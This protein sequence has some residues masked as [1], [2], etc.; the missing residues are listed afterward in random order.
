MTAAVMT[1]GDMIQGATFSPSY[2]GAFIDWIDRT[3]NT[4]K[5]YVNH[6]RQFWAWT[7][8]REILQPIREDI[9][10]FREW[11]L[12]EHEAITIDKAGKWT[13]RKD[14]ATGKPFVLAC[15]PT[16]TAQY[17]RSIK[18]FFRWTS[19]AGLY[20]DIAENI[21]P[22]KVSYTMHRRDALTVEQV[23]AVES[24]I[25]ESSRQGIISAEQ[26][27]K[28]TKGRTHRK[29]EQ[30]ARLLAMYQLAVI[31]GLRTV[32]LSRARVKDFEERGGRYYL[33]IQ[34][35]GHSEADERKPLAPEVA[36]A[37]KEYLHIRAK[38]FSLN[39]NSP[40][41]VATGNRNGGGKLDPRTISTIIKDAL[42]T[43]GLNSSRI[44]AHSLRHTA[45]T[46][47]YGITHDL[48]GVQK[49]MRHANP[50]TTEIYL[51]NDTEKQDADFT[52]K[53]YKLFH[54]ENFSI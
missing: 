42:K 6:L 31:N 12:S 48:Y 37:I 14:R 35:K 4:A 41:F 19:A 44:T 15:T 23:K 11:L 1:T 33:Y 20:P 18:Q 24:S 38:G 39:G 52:D 8:Y 30:G 34:G 13:Y 43:A 46:A 49:Y 22:P 9:I 16:T 25:K 28:D 3:E 45:G 53:L 2:F 54:E 21:R 47:L 7:L 50:A 40:L 5:S 32:E 51:H 10:A 29:T 26:E 36:D 27:K 17:I